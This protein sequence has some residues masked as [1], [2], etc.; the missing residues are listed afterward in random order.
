[1]LRWYELALLRQ[2]WPT[3]GFY[4]TADWC[5]RLALL[6]GP[7]NRPGA[8]AARMPSWP[9]SHAVAASRIRPFDLCTRAAKPL[10]SSSRWARPS[11]AS[12]VSQAPGWSVSRSSGS[13]CASS[14]RHPEPE[15]RSE[16]AE[17]PCAA[18]PGS[19]ATPPRPGTATAAPPCTPARARRPVRGMAQAHSVARS[20][21]QQP[22]DGV[23]GW[24]NLI[25][26]WH[27]PD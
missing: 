16:S 19:P 8:G 22:Q 1:M 18:G 13:R 11:S 14:A 2:D 25:A 5:Q 27:G 12:S 10:G 3:S 24:T 9:V 17:T 15:N 6:L 4:S 23:V 21:C 7:R 26:P 20:H